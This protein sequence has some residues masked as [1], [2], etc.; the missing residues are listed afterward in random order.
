MSTAREKTTF[1]RGRPQRGQKNHYQSRR[2]RNNRGHRRNH[3]RNFTYRKRPKDQTN[4]L[5]KQDFFNVGLLVLERKFE[6]NGLEDIVQKHP[7]VLLAQKRGIIV[8]TRR[9]FK[10]KMERSGRE[11]SRVNSRN[12]VI[13]SMLEHLRQGEELP[14][15]YQVDDEEEFGEDMLVG[16][17]DKGGGD[18]PEA[19]NDI[20]GM[21]QMWKKEEEEEKATV[22]MESLMHLSSD[23]EEDDEWGQQRKKLE[24]SALNLTLEK[25]FT[26]A[27]LAGQTEVLDKEI[28]RPTVED[29]EDE[30]EDETDEDGPGGDL[31]SL[32]VLG[33]LG[34]NQ[35]TFFDDLD[36]QI[37]ESFMIAKKEEPQEQAGE[38][39]N[40]LDDSWKPEFKNDFELALN[41]E[42]LENMRDDASINME[43]M[44]QQVD[45][46][47]EDVWAG[48]E[49]NMDKILNG[50]SI[51]EDSIMSAHVD[52]DGN[53]EQLPEFGLLD[54]HGS[55][56]QVLGELENKESFETGDSESVQTAKTEKKE[57][58]PEEKEKRK[59]IFLSRYQLMIM[60]MDET[61]RD[62]LRW[63]RANKKKVNPENMPMNK[64]TDTSVAKFTSTQYKIFSMLCR[65]QMFYKTWYYQDSEGEKHGPFMSFDM[66]IWNLEGKLKTD[67]LISP[68]DKTYLCYDQFND[69]DNSI[70]DLMEDVIKEQERVFKM[71]ALKLR[72]EQMKR[73]EK[74]RGRGR[75][76]GRSRGNRH[77][78]R[79]YRRRDQPRERNYDRE[80]PRKPY[81]KDYGEFY[82]KKKSGRGQGNR[83]RHSQEQ[84]F[85]PQNAD[86]FKKKPKAERV[87]EEEFP[88]LG[89]ETESQLN[90]GNEPV[91]ANSNGQSSQS[92][93]KASRF[94]RKKAE[95][96]PQFEEVGF[97]SPDDIPGI[98]KVAEPVKKKEQASMISR[99]DD[100]G[101]TTKKSNKKR[102]KR[103]K[104]AK[105]PPEDDEKNEELTDNIKKMLDI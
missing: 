31:K 79:N 39:G 1:R 101:K 40:I 68:D 13:G 8:D 11:A 63:Q 81:Q 5:T 77:R 54:D 28:G 48:F 25:G 41:Q 88:T 2:G 33:K 32:N 74:K 52:A 72:E 38:I 104:H 35:D 47:Y 9:E 21:F 80:Q 58:T 94:E 90:R 51:M 66:D 89:A 83:E 12:K 15:W 100:E 64:V 49:S 87:N 16:G 10:Q 7:D 37:E 23:E 85:N 78:E 22:M 26:L 105:R 42:V 14:Q 60:M 61:A 6:Q 20:E 4:I 97:E 76:R 30:R 34:E 45:N 75:G 56:E 73:Q 24:E 50:G 67:F 3:Q 17:F 19:G 103:R 44:L 36:K 84:R 92:E 46:E 65:G 55:T 86:L 82:F 18:A 27:T 91:E 96:K 93:P 98:S 53:Q 69:R 70:F 29:M 43:D 102:R 59:R 71:N 99:W 95:I 57:L 62:T